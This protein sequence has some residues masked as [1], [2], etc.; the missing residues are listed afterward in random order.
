LRTDVDPELLVAVFFNFVSG[1]ISRIGEMGD[2]VQTEFKMSTQTIFTQIYR[3][4][5][6]GLK[7]PS[8]NR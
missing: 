8:S 3:I 4:F 7:A 6:D 5:L 1:M 2:K